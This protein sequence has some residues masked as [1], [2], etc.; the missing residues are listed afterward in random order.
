MKTLITTVMVTIFAATVPFDVALGQTE[1]DQKASDV[2]AG[3]LARFQENIPRDDL[4]YVKSCL[5]QEGLSWNDT[6]RV[7]RLDFGR[8]RQAWL[9][10]GL[11]PC[12]AGNA[13]GLMHLYIRV[14]DGWREI[15]DD[16]AQSLEVCAEAVPPCRAPKPRP[17]GTHDW[18]D[19][20]LW[21]H[22]SASEG[23]Q[24]VYR[25]NGNV[26]REVFCNHV[27][28]QS[29]EGKRY[30]QPRSIPCDVPFDFVAAL[31]NDL[32]YKTYL[33]HIKP[34]VEA[35]NEGL[36]VKANVRVWWFDLNQ[37]DL[38]RPHEALVLQPSQPCAGENDGEMFLYIRAGKSW[39]PILHTRGDSLMVD[40]QSD[41]WCPPQKAFPNRSSATQHWPD[42]IIGR[43]TSATERHTL[44]FRFDGNGY[45]EIQ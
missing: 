6:A 4:E 38:T 9:V 11:G 12:L 27:N 15:L 28:Y 31:Q 21:H 25:F 32:E 7:T 37:L 34:C 42:L 8:S 10:E 30:S 13:N 18:P 1:P 41:P 3:L 29:P 39:R 24:H 45:N 23:E 5:E 40:R 35:E 26:Y 36:A 2:R 16:V 19:V 14:G 33:R 20:A 44:C 17:P 22:G 43:N